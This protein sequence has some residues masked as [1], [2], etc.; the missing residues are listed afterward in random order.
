MSIHKNRRKVEVCHNCHHIL[1]PEDNF[2]ANCG[3]E[4]H[5]LKVGVGQLLYDVFEG[6]TN[7]DTKFYNT[8]KSI[9]SQP[10][11]ITKDF[12]EGRRARYVPPIRLY[13]IVSFVFFIAFDE[14]VE[15]GLNSTND[16]ARGVID[17]LKGDS[18]RA[19][20]DEDDEQESNK[21][22][23]NS[24]QNQ[25]LKA[26]RQKREDKSKEIA[27]LNMELDSA[28]ARE[29]TSLQHTLEKKIA[30]DEKQLKTLDKQT[31]L[32]SQAKGFIDYVSNF[33]I[34]TDEIL[35]EM[36]VE[37]EDTLRAIIDSLPE[38]KQ[39]PVLIEIQKQ[40]ALDSIHTEAITEPAEDLK[41]YFTE[42][43]GKKGKIEYTL[44]LHSL[45]NN[46]KVPVWIEGVKVF[47]KSSDGSLQNRMY[48]KR[49]LSMSNE[50]LDSLIVK[51]EGSK[52]AFAFLKRGLRRNV[53]Y[54]ELAFDEDAEKA[55]GEMVHF[56]VNV[57]SFMMFILMPLVALM[58]KISYSK[59]IHSAIWYPFKWVK[60][61]FRLLKY[62]LTGGFM[63]QKPFPEMPKL[64]EGQTRF[65]YEHLIFSIHIHS[66]FMLMLMIFIGIGIIVGH[67]N[68][69]LSI[70]LIVFMIYF[71]MSLKVVYRQSW[72]KTIWKSMVLF[73]MY[74]F[75]FTMVLGI[76]GAIKFAL[77]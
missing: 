69:A 2:C 33:D 13:F 27:N 5:D 49:L 67:W 58:L 9:F 52:S 57:I 3:Q 23:D 10:G 76:T 50:D 47:T 21:K 42:R 36:N 48:K 70:A 64:F 66:I 56:G 71:A 39:R 15:M 14:L 30:R 16:V 55:I 60:Y 19:N 74:C 20:K 72:L 12:L 51:E 25:A 43:L 77:Q 44:I 11:K 65:Y 40:L 29:D 37:R 1:K 17:G 24:I 45:K 63:R 8:A 26:V 4:N 68:I 18:K 75:T 31:K 54:Y 34:S 6:I 59:R 35:D 7:F 22:E 28:I 62:A 32:A 53:T 73:C 61:L 41:A 46:V 38:Y